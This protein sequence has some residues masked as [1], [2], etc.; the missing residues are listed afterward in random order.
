MYGLC[1]EIHF[2]ELGLGRQIVTSTFVSGY[3]RGFYAYT[4][5]AKLAPSK[6]WGAEGVAL[7]YTRDV[8]IHVQQYC[9]C[10]LL[11]HC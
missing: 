8:G 3:I 1:A 10:N 7:Q 4:Q 6:K 2:S 9:E 11:H 5:W